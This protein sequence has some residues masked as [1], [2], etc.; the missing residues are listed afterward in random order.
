MIV[1]GTVVIFEGGNIGTASRYDEEHNIGE[2]SFQ[3]LKRTHEIGV[4]YE[5]DGYYPVSLVFKKSE[6]I[7]VVIRQLEKIKEKMEDKENGK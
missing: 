3:E 5:E 4:Q 2:L 6:S 1:N 7:D